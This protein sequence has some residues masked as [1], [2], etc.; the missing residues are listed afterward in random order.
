MT[1]FSIGLDMA[2]TVYIQAD[3]LSEAQGK[4]QPLL[5]KRIDARDH[6]WF[7]DASFGSSALP[8]I[9]FA[10]AMAILGPV[11][12]EGL[13]TIGIDEV[14]R[15]MSSCPN[16]RKTSV[17]P[18]SGGRRESRSRSL[19]WADLQ[20]QTTAIM[21]YKDASDALA[22]LTQIKEAQAGVHWELADRWFEQKCLESAEFP[23]VLT[24]NIQVVAVSDALPLQEHPSVA[25]TRKR[26]H[27]T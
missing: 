19:F 2:A 10:T 27:A 5:S 18:C 14:G 4:L 9:S 23:L 1:Y 13:R 22:L 3:S 6:G 15:L 8:E 26:F 21:Q 24:P 20:V 7:S 16:A 17:L 12:G 25:E 11:W